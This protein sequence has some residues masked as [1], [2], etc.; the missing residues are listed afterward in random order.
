MSGNGATD[1]Q[2]DYMLTLANKVNGTSYR[3]LSQV[4]DVLGLSSFQLQ[5]GITK[6]QA[7][8]LID[9]L[10]KQLEEEGKL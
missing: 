9:Q 5:R 6:P 2:L 1:S 3:Y 8:A 10:K 4:R 7:S